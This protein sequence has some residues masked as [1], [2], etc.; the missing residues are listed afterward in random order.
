MLVQFSNVFE[1]QCYL[2]VVFNPVDPVTGTEVGAKM[3]RGKK[4][5][6]ALSADANNS[7]PPKKLAAVRELSDRDPDAA[8]NFE[9]LKAVKLTNVASLAHW[10]KHWFRYQMIT[11]NPYLSHEECLLLAAGS[12]TAA[13]TR[14]NLTAEKCSLFLTFQRLLLIAFDRL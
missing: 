2:S 1:S 4:R 11:I 8:Y 5:E 12:Y 7:P 10:A 13:P 9:W 6:R 14:I 3:K